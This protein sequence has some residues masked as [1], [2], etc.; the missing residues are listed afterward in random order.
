MKLTNRAL[1]LASAA[2]IIPYMKFHSVPELER[3]ISDAGFEIHDAADLAF[4]QSSDMKY[5]FAR[6]VAARKGR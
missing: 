2:R 3:S 1:S 6:F 4:A 5:V